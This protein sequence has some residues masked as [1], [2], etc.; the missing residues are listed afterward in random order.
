[1]RAF[2]I[3]IILTLIVLGS[4]T[5]LHAEEVVITAVGDIMLAGKWTPFLKK[6]G[7]GYPFDHVRAELAGSDIGLAN[8]ESPIAASGTEFT[9]K[10]FRF[11]AEP[12]VAKALRD[13]GFTAVTLANNHTM[14]F[15]ADALLE[16]LE[17]LHATNIVAVGAGKNS[18]DARA[19]A[20]VT[21]KGKK[22]A[23]LGYS[24]TQPVEFFAGRN[25]P[26]TAPGYEPFVR[27]D[28]SA[29]RAAADYVIVSFHWG[30]EATGTVQEYQTKMA[31]IAID[32]G[33]DIVIG[34]HP[35]VLQGIERYKTGI[36]FYSLGNF[37]FASKSTTADVSALFRFRLDDSHRTVE[38]IPLDVLYRR[39]GF[40]PRP[41]SGT[42]GAAT[43]EKLNKLSEEFAT[44]IENKDG[45]YVI[46]F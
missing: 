10:K 16:T 36:I 28:I 4:T 8:L 33:A 27:T 31:H 25:R 23:L 37:A 13:A 41:L 34:H 30:K 17:H 26:G 40:Q 14:D 15:G 45:R 12:P 19:M 32:S 11:R 42:R 22:I 2:T 20:I 39:V 46:V 1:M 9:G 43:I 24:L 29:A 18:A 35:H 38:V 6:N 44:T 5:C 7:Y 3:H 21:A